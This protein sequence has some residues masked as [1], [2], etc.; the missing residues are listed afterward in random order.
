METY[1][2][3][4]FW[5]RRLEREPQARFNA[6]VLGWSF[7]DT[8]LPTFQEAPL[9]LSTEFGDDDNPHT[10]S[11]LLVSA[12][13]AV[14]KTTLAREIARVTDS[15]YVDLAVADPVGANTLI[16]GLAR[17]GL[18][19][20][21]QSGSV[22]VL[23]D[24]LDEAR[25]RVT[26][27]AFWTF[28]ADVA[29]LSAERTVPTVLFGRTGAI[30]DAWLVLEEL[31]NDVETAVLEI[32]YYDQA[33]S[34]KFA[35][36]IVRDLNPSR[37]HR[38]V[39]RKAV[40]LLLNNLRVATET[41]GDR[42]AGYA[43]VLQAVAKHVAQESNPGDLVSRLEHGTQPVTLQ[44]IVARIMERERAKLEILEFDDPS[45]REG[46]YSADEQLERLVASV[47]GSRQ[48]PI[49]R[50]QPS[51][52]KKYEMALQ[53]WVSEHP[54]VDGSGRPSSEVF[55]AAIATQALRSRS[56]VIQ[57]KALERE[58]ERGAAANPFLSEFCLTDAEEVEPDHIGIIY[59]SVRAGLALDDTAT[60]SIEPAGD[61]SADGELF[62][63]AE[64]SVTRRDASEPRVFS[65]KIDKTGPIVLG[66]EIEDVEVV[67]P[68]TRV[69]VGTGNEVV[70]IAPVSIDCKELTVSAK[71]VVVESSSTWAETQE[72]A[73]VRLE[74]GTYEGHSMSE[75]PIVR[76]NV[77]LS[78]W[79]PDATNYPWTSFANMPT[80]P[81]GDPTTAEALRRLAN[82]VVAT[83]ARNNREPSRFRGKLEHSRMTKGSGRAV[84]DH[85]IAERILVLQHPRYI[86]DVDRLDKLT[87]TSYGDCVERKFGP[88]AI[89]FVTEALK[90]A[91]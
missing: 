3:D 51:D 87:G 22:A 10:S 68:D 50:M 41:D 33:A 26:Q 7:P 45:I 4:D 48:P 75:V 83:R 71:K 37:G 55:A 61:S 39:Q 20:S 67:V 57:E 76:G 11:I 58:L 91:E 89:A 52:A 2:I 59:A 49:P 6:P 36:A 27:E 43:P 56:K 18:Y 12:P 35:D 46:L 34:V 9:T 8:E 64:M 23:I 66:A 14:G 31:G 90:A 73:V 69:E 16:G 47:Y 1:K 15:V 72:D 53:T 79:W 25:L 28:L 44:N 19:D 24:G 84:L 40:T 77:A 62:V 74:A 86:L 21:W 5:I 70:L 88:K 29:E 60:L 78:V 81:P 82:F 30:Q 17:S 85:M 32:G 42:F 38:E 54:F 80:I 13:G 63:E 65:L